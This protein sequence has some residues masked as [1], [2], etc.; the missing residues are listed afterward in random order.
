MSETEQVTWHD[1]LLAATKG[2]Q[3]GAIAKC[4]LNRNVAQGLRQYYGQASITSDGFVMCNFMDAQGQEHMG[5]FV[6]SVDDLKRNVVGV[7]KHLGLTDD[8]REAWYRACRAWIGLD[9]SGHGIG[10]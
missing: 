10:V 8:E 6:G 2:T 9:Y 5:A 1:R 7:A 3:T 4:V